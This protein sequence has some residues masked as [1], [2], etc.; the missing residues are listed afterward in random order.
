MRT[1][2]A[3]AIV[4]AAAPAA[5]DVWL[6]KPPPQ[7]APSKP[8]VRPLLGDRWTVSAMPGLGWIEVDGT[9]GGGMLIAPTV[10]RTFDRFE[11]AGE[12]IALDW[13]VEDPMR[14]SGT[15]HRLGGELRFQIARTRIQEKMTLDAAVGAGLGLQHLTRDHG[16]P[17]D[18]SDGSFGVVLRMLADL[19][20][21][22]KERTLFGM[23]MSARFIYTRGAGAADRGF[24]FTFGVPL[25]W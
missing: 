11:V 12:Y 15:L 25:G 7:P 14:S 17:I 5:A 4:L 9:R 6:V 19:D 10:T 1:L 20:N 3:L 24:V 23:E 13:N 8:Y 22:D 18:R 16:A 2:L 21:R